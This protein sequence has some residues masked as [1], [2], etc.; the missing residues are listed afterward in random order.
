MFILR[1]PFNNLQLQCPTLS[2]IKIIILDKKLIVFSI[3]EDK[4]EFKN[5]L[6]YIENNTA[7]AIEVV[8]LLDGVKDFIQSKMKMNC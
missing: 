8:N 3:L 4:K 5:E 2:K 6:E 7:L 1:Q